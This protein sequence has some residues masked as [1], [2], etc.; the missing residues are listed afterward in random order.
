M[1]LNDYSPYFAEMAEIAGA[2]DPDVVAAYQADVTNALS[3]AGVDLSD[4]ALFA[5]ALSGAHVAL[6]LAELSGSVRGGASVFGVGLLV[7]F[8]SA[9][10]DESPDLTEE[11][12]A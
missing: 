11:G 8:V 7:A 6:G 3:E 12:A 4:P 10:S 2:S 1:P 5:A 9:Q